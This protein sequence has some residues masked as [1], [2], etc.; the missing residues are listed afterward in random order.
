MSYKFQFLRERF[1]CNV[2]LKDK[3]FV[4]VDVSNGQYETENEEVYEYLLKRSKE[5]NSDIVSLDNVKAI[6]ENAQ[7]KPK[8]VAG[9]RSSKDV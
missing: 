4:A 3:T 6:V 7:T 8:I 1:A 9:G 5:P 2:P